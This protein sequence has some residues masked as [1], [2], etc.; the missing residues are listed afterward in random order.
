MM[1][2][3]AYCGGF[4]NSLF[5]RSSVSVSISSHLSTEFQLF[6]TVWRLRSWRQFFLSGS[7]EC[8]SLRH[9][10]ISGAIVELRET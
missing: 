7:V 6:V 1:H 9:L 5:A 2:L 3:E 8:N 4:F 10:G